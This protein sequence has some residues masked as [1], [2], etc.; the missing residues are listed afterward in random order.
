MFTGSA[1]H[2]SY[3]K[4]KQVT[5]SHRLLRKNKSI[6]FMNALNEK[7]KKCKRRTL[8]QTVRLAADL[9]YLIYH[10]DVKTVKQFNPQYNNNLNRA[11]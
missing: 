7:E 4:N 10:I 2:I 11:L 8:G 1:L 3:L 5:K 6:S 9:S